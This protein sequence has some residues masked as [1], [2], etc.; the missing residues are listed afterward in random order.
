MDS[1]SQ[2]TVDTLKEY[3]TVLIADHDKRYEQRH[4]ANK[5]AIAIAIANAQVAN[6]KAELSIEKRLEGTNEWRNAL[7]EHQR[8][9]M[10]RSEAQVLFEA[11]TKR[12]DKQDQDENRRMNSQGREEGR[13]KGMIDG[14][15]RAIAVAGALI[16]AYALTRG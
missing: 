10:P 11:M 6:S 4:Q 3:L 15:G 5:E 2:W 7:N 12:M 9:Y 13:A 8:T 1:S 14:W 16:A